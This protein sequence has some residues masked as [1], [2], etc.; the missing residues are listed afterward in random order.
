M[1]SSLSNLLNP[2]S[3]FV[4]L[5][6]SSTA[7]CLWFQQLELSHHNVS[8]VQRLMRIV[9]QVW[10]MTLTFKWPSRFNVLVDQMPNDLLVIAFADHFPCLYDTLWG[11]TVIGYFCFLFAILLFGCRSA[12]SGSKTSRRR[13]SS[14]GHKSPRNRPGSKDGD[15]KSPGNCII[16]YSLVTDIIKKTLPKVQK[17]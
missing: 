4:F 11:G 1:S 10:A 15:A 14:S 6:K 3:W 16:L 7:S 17:R 8:C 2:V 9:C 12:G 13:K 5:L